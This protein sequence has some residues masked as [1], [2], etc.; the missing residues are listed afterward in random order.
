MTLHSSAERADDNGPENETS[1]PNQQQHPTG[2]SSCDCVLGQPSYILWK[3]F[4]L[5]GLCSSKKFAYF[6]FDFDCILHCFIRSSEV[7]YFPK[8]HSDQI[9][10][11]ILKQNS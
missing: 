8:A 6:Y 3:V 9:Y 4:Q 5:L 1:S 11:A 10:Y 2:L 7:D